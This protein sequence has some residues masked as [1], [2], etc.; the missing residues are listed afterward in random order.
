MT[1]RYGEEI[2]HTEDEECERPWYKAT[3]EF[4]VLLCFFV[5]VCG[6]VAY[7]A[8][9]KSVTV[10]ETITTE[11]YSGVFDQ[12]ITTDWTVLETKATSG[13]GSFFMPLTMTAMSNS[14][15]VEN[16]YQDHTLFV[17][18]KGAR[19]SSIE[20]SVIEGD[21]EHILTAA[22]RENSGELHI[23]LYMD[24]V[25]DYDISK[26]NGK[27]VITPY[28][29]H[30]RYEKV[31]MLVP[32]YDMRDEAD[33][34]AKVAET[35]ISLMATDITT[36]ETADPDGTQLESESGDKDIA[37]IYSVRNPGN[38]RT[39]EEIFSLIRDSEADIVV[40]L[41][42]SESEN[43]EDYG[44]R[45]VYNAEYFI[46]GINNAVVAESFLRNIAVSANDKATAIDE[47][48]PDDILKQIEIPSA[49]VSIGYLTNEEEY[50]YL[51]DERYREKIAEG[52]I[53]AI[54]EVCEN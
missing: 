29:A 51:K 27:L 40:F 37:R 12:D 17:R 13:D 36:D 19:G 52:I 21:T 46:P 39:E 7:R 18:I 31:V 50:G 38:T 14:V 33:V 5:I 24:G 34:T 8:S 15:S 30:D 4:L 32:A 42:L 47:A 43:T 26:E 48:G 9:A 20:N 16:Y 35:A 54:K 10:D 1:F 49:R 41:E 45:A 6:C 44:M 2:N 3:A 28:K 11:D 22:Y 23:S 53:N 25:W